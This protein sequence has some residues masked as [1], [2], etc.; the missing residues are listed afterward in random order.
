MS[1]HVTLSILVSILVVLI[2]PYFKTYSAVI[3]SE[4]QYSAKNNFE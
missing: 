4:I 2:T 1:D 3:V